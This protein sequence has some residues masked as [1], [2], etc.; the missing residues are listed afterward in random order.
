LQESNQEANNVRKVHLQKLCSGFEK[1][2]MLESENISKYFARIL[3]ILN[4]MKRYGEKMEETHV[5]EK[6]LCSLQKKFHHVVVMI[7]ESQNMDFF[8]IQGLMGKLQ[9]HEKRVNEIQEDVGVQTLFSKQ[10]GSRYS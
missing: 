9:A 8:S 6:I 10:D 5:V 4:Q 7:E 2:H 3:A 1:L